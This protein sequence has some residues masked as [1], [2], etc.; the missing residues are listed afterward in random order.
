M[1]S[2]AGRVVRPHQTL[3]KVIPDIDQ[4]PCAL[5]THGCLGN[6]LLRARWSV[7]LLFHLHDFLKIWSIAYT[8]SYQPTLLGRNSGSTQQGTQAAR[9]IMR[10]P[11]SSQY[12]RQEQGTQISFEPSKQLQPV[13]TKTSEVLGEPMPSRATVDSHSTLCCSGCGERRLHYW[14]DALGDT[15]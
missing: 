14:H 4:L 7:L 10:Y 13:A 6:T 2:C 11:H 3:Y 8:N 15:S 1:A 9:P 12:C 5:A